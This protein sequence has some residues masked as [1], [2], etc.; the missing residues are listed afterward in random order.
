[1]R[2]MR[3]VVPYLKPTGRLVYST[4]SIEPEEN[5]SVVAFIGKTEPAL[6]FIETKSSLP[7]RDNIDGAFAALFVKA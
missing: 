2:I 5:E 7:V 1:T 4:C 3:A 6:H